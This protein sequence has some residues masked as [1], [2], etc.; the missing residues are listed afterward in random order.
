MISFLAFDIFGWFKDIPSNLIGIGTNLLRLIFSFIAV[1]LYEVMISLYN[2][3]DVLCFTRLLDSEALGNLSQRI[4]LI[5]GLIMLFYVVFAFIKLMVNPDQLTDG[6]KGAVGIIKK[7]LIVIV[8][9]GVSSFV[10]E[11]LFTLQSVIVKNH[12]IT[13][14]VLPYEVNEE[15]YNNKMGNVLAAELFYA[16]Y[17]VDDAFYDESGEKL[18][19]DWEND[20]DVKTCETIAWTLKND[21]YDTG[22][23][24]LTDACLYDTT[25]INNAHTGDA[26]RYI[27][28]FNW[29]FSIAMGIAVDYFLISYCIAVGVR[30]IRLLVLEV[31]SPMA[32]VSY[33]LPKDD[34]FFKKWLKSYFSTY[35]DVFIR[36]GI[37]NFVL[38]IGITVLSQGKEWEFWIHVGKQNGQLNYLLI[39][40]MIVALLS[41][42]KKAPDLLKELG[43]DGGRFGGFHFKDAFGVQRGLGM[44]AGGAASAALGMY[45]GGPIGM[46]GG[47]F[48]GMK[49]GFS[50]K[51]VRDSLKSGWNA[52][53]SYNERAAEWAAN[54]GRSGLS[55][56]FSGVQQSMGMNPTA[57]VDQQLKDLET[58]NSAYD[59][60]NTFV[61]AAEERAEKQILRGSYNDNKHAAKALDAKNNVEIYRQQAADLKES[62][63]TDSTDSSGHVKTAHDQYVAKLDELRKFAREAEKEFNTELK[64]AKAEYITDAMNGTGDVEDVVVT[65]NMD[66]A[67]TVVRANS[68]MA[69]FQGV[70]MRDASGKRVYKGDDAA[71]NPAGFDA[72]NNSAK[73]RKSANVN[74]TY[75]IQQSAGYKAGQADKKFNGGSK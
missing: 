22:D 64:A 41:F 48:R 5:L 39:A 19:S 50:G 49:S 8:M 32:F 43:F 59:Q 52:Q 45:E 68:R 35:L 70:S 51:S 1:K 65:Q 61:T 38:F 69:G 2:V 3:F 72:V 9:I 47:A 34:T 21:I 56:F 28:Y 55:R 10:F 20:N 33:L 17:H 63:F 46:L 15:E 30:M 23:F 13:R 18:S 6:S 36:I 67:E 62:D 58:E 40:F 42:A 14:I 44:L 29:L 7:V 4:G 53:K 60:F 57:D 26:P 11:T 24:F 73:A 16:F 25:P 74:T 12:L 75:T 54:G 66:S 37:I 31:I 71:G 27:I